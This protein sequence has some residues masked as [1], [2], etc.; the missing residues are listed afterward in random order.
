VLD[1]LRRHCFSCDWFEL[2]C[3]HHGRRCQLFFCGWP[4]IITQHKLIYRKDHE[5]LGHPIISRDPMAPR[6][7]PFCWRSDRH[8]IALE[9]HS[10]KSGIAPPHLK[11]PSR[12]GLILEA[13]MLKRVIRQWH[14]LTFEQKVSVVRLLLLV[15]TILA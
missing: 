10:T 11:L 13:I 9:P 3:Q 6:Q 1:K 12:L 15:L 5:D 4:C 2:V 7:A 14:G 8:G